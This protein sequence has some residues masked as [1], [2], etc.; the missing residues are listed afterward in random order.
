MRWRQHG[1][2]LSWKSAWM[3]QCQREV[4]QQYEDDVHDRALVCDRLAP[5]LFRIGRRHVDDGHPDA[6]REAFR[7]ALRYARGGGVSGNVRAATWVLVLGL[8]D[9]LRDRA[10]QAFVSISRGLAGHQA[11]AGMSR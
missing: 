3:D 2:N 6:A 7:D 10:G 8:P 1:E 4:L 9:G 11:R 5:L